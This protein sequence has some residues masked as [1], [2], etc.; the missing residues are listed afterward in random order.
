M[1]TVERITP[2]DQAVV[3][4][5]PRVA[6]TATMIHAKVHA[7]AFYVIVVA[8]FSLGF[9]AGPLLLLH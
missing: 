9:V 1:T 3:A 2:P 4:S 7:G 8:A 5:T 6:R